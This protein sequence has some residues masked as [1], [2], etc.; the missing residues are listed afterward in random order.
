MHLS[1]NCTALHSFKSNHPT[2][3]TADAKGKCTQPDH[4][5][6]GENCQ[7][8]T[9]NNPLTLNNSP[10][11]IPI[12]DNLA[13]VRRKHSAVQCPIPACPGNQPEITGSGEGLVAVPSNRIFISTTKDSCAGTEIVEVTKIDW[14]EVPFGRNTTYEGGPLGG[15]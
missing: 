6:H 7:T 8:T 9:T 15:A 5:R 14:E 2:Q 4:G 11:T 10:T 1:N 13:L 12:S 3:S